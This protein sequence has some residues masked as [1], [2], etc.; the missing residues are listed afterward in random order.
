MLDVRREAA[1]RDVDIKAGYEKRI[2]ALEAQIAALE[3]EFGAHREAASEHL[4]A[5]KGELESSLKEQGRLSQTIQNLSDSLAGKESEL[6]EQVS[7][8]NQLRAQL[9]PGQQQV[10]SSSSS[11]AV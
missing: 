8:M 5:A 2:A 3:R 6:A 10:A 1:A 7:F 4:A 11:S 9:G